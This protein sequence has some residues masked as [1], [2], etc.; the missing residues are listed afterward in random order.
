MEYRKEVL[1]AGLDDFRV[2]LVQMWDHLGLP[3][4]TPAQLD[5]A[6]EL[7]H[8]PRRQII[9]GFRGVGK[10]WIT[11]AFVL[12]TLLLDPQKKILVVSASQQLADDFSKFCKQ[13]IHSMELLHHLAP[14][15][16]QRNS[17]LSFDVGPARPSK[18][19]SV[20]S[21]GIT[22]QITGSRADLVVADDIEIPKNSYTHLLRER[23]S[24]L[25]KEFDAILKPNGRV[26]Y[27]GTPQ[28]EQTLY[29]KLEKRDYRLRL[30]PSEVR[31]RMDRYH[32]RLAPFVARLFEQGVPDGT[33]VDAARF[34]KLDLAERLASYGAT[35]YALQFLLD[36]TP[37]E[38]DKHPLKLHDLMIHDID[39]DLGHVKLVWGGAKEVTIQDLDVG[40]FDGD[41]YVRP[42][43]KSDEMAKYTGTVMAID[44][45]GKG[46]DETGY[47]IVKYLHGLLYA[48]DIGGFLDGFAETTLQA[49]AAKAARWGV[50]DIII[51]ENYGGGMFGQLLKPHVFRVCSARF[52]TEWDGWS[53]TQKE[54]RILDT[55]EPL[56]QSHKVVISRRVIEEDLAVQRDRETYSFVQQM[57][58]MARIRG[59]LPHEDRVEALSMACAYW[60][61]KMDRDQ[62][63]S[64]QRHKAGLMDAELK[65]F[66]DHVLGR[67]PTAGRSRGYYRWRN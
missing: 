61:E 27:L 7:Q 17:S 2:F 24:E 14:R 22:G 44:P 30:W 60:T 56:I 57:T 53:S 55:L 31:G 35:G 20:K 42:A 65:K 34:D 36:T 32:G 16:D 5:I 10:S 48:V 23:L 26:V 38:L 28:V 46:K 51:E 18:D 19:P 8:G 66:M 40:G 11:V 62:D 58:R 1:D 49:L 37:S 67:H 59:C 25:V 43:W 64:L 47:A 3:T 54:L 33:P 39:V 50:N 13:L 12:W 15:D 21:A 63:K 41:Y 6:Y 45:S 52:D 4:P 29:T 9:C